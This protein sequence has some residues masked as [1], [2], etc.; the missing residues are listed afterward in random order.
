VR[1]WL[2]FFSTRFWLD[3]LDVRLFV[4][5]GGSGGS[6]TQKYEWNDQ[7]KQPWMDVLKNATDLH[8]QAYNPYPYQ[9]IA[10]MNSDQTDAMD[11]IRNFTDTG[12]M[13]VTQAANQQT[14][15]TLEG[16]YLDSNPYASASNPYSGFGS[17]FNTV[18]QGGLG[19]IADAYKNGTSAETTRLMN[20]AGV[21]GG[22]AHQN[23]V[24]NN[25]GALAKQMG[26]YVAGMTNDQ[27]NRSAG[28]AESGLQRG[29]SAYEGERGRMVG[30]VGA[31]QNAQNLALQGANARMGIGD[32]QRGFSQDQLNQYYNDWQTQQQYPYQQLDYLSGILGRAQGG[33]SP[34]V[35]STQSGYAASPYSQILGAGLL[36]YGMMK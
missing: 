26:Q 14:Q 5:G 20:N 25:E 35:T 22:S 36:G 7:M 3:L 1:Q 32:I 33:V 12:G 11:F 15:D 17:Q 16:N 23:A 21:F 9:R 2:D 18:L 29:A 24:A 28:L 27:Y 31:G 8:G 30:S 10:G 34:N 19:D 6:G 4:S 13:P